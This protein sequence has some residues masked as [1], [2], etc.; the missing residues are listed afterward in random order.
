M[1]DYFDKIF[2][3]NRKIDKE[4]M[5]ITNKILKDNNINYV[6]Q[7]ATVIDLKNSHLTN[8]IIGCA[9][10]HLKLWKKVIKLKLKNAVIFEDDIFLVNNWDIILKDGIKDVPDNWDILTLGNFGIKTKSDI[11]DS[12]FN[13]I[14]Y[15]IIKYLNI[16]YECENRYI[17]RNIIRP[18]FFTGLY[19]YA[20]SNKGAHK[21]LQYINNVNDIKFHIDVM[22][23]C[24]NNNLNI[25]SLNND[26]V[27]QRLEQST[28]NTKNTILKNNKIKFH[29]EMLNYIDSKNIKYDYYM[30]VP[31]YKLN[32]LQYEIIINGWF[33]FIMFIIIIV[34]IIITLKLKNSVNN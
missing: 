21:L 13:F 16:G 34:N 17:T 8:E 29:F 19:G 5:K 23:S 33:I 1:N 6:R 18:Y 22:I 9:L 24:H 26:I 11:F 31:I 2:V 4:R 3:I 25:Y 28:I 10:S 14:F 15:C 20:I 27:Y 30:N 7:E 32:I 12:P